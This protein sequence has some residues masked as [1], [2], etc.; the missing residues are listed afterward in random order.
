MGTRVSYPV[1]VKRKVIEMRL[2]GVPVKEVMEE[3]NNLL[4]NNIPSIKGQNM[5]MKQR[6]Y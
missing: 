2:T 1:K 5:K 3:L 6:N 4:E